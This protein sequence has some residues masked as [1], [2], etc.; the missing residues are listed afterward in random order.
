MRALAVLYI[1]LAVVGCRSTGTI[2]KKSNIV[3]NI[4]FDTTWRASESPYAVKGNLW[5]AGPATLKIEKGTEILFESSACM[6]VEG[7]LLVEGTRNEPVTFRAK[8]ISAPGEPG[9]WEHINIKKSRNNSLIKS[10]IFRNSKAALFIENDSVEIVD[11]LFE[12]NK[13]GIYIKNSSPVITTGLFRQNGT[14][15]MS[16]GK[17]DGTISK[18]S[19]EENKIAAIHG[20]DAFSPG[21]TRNVFLNNGFGILIKYTRLSLPKH[22]AR[23]DFNDFAG[24]QKANLYL[25]NFPADVVLKVPSNYWGTKEHKGITG[26]VNASGALENPQYM[27]VPRQ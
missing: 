25:E 7:S 10:A 3:K 14:G 4:Y 22:L 9:I 15:I 5:I 19:F 20:V 23:I 12:Y 6:T 18:N 8:E 27:H 1:C 26:P 24:N 16:H 13:H 11:C 17:N 2:D 21:I